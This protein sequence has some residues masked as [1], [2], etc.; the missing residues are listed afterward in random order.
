MTTYKNALFTKRNYD[1]TNI[2]FCQTEGNPQVN[3]D[4]QNMTW[5]ETTEQIP[6]GM[7]QL[8]LCDGVRYFGYL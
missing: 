3:G 1:C 4:R 7:T 5:V 2:V 6:A 8:Y